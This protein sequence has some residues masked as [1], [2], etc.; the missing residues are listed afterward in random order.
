M[1]P[2]YKINLPINILNPNVDPLDF[3]LKEMFKKKGLYLLDDVLFWLSKEFIDF[4]NDQYNFNPGTILFIMPPN[5]K[6]APHIDRGGR[7]YGLDHWAINYYWN[8]QNSTMYW[9]E[10]KTE[11]HVNKS[12]MYCNEHKTE[13]P[14]GKNGVNVEVYHPIWHEDE[15]SLIHQECLKPF[16]FIRTDIPHAVEN[17][18]ELKIRYCLSIRPNTRDKKNTYEEAYTM[19]R[20]YLHEY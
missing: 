5:D 13:G 20:K 10:P 16:S 18:D 14:V 15:V 8:W 3:P 17:F 6:Q 1:K 7:P 2:C 12:T 19:F 4:C 11:G 9:Y